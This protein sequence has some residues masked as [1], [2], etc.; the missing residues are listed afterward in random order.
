M[1]QAVSA[2]SSSSRS[3]LEATITHA[4]SIVECEPLRIVEDR[5]LAM[6]TVFAGVRE[7][8]YCIDV[9]EAS[10]Q[11]DLWCKRK[12]RRHRRGESSI[13]AIEKSLENFSPSKFLSRIFETANSLSSDERVEKIQ[14]SE[15]DSS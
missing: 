6:P 4:T 11:G 14:C 8:L 1:L 15:S 2:A 12:T 7:A 3:R 10:T 9:L 13:D 5:K